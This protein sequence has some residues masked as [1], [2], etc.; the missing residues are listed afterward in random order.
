MAFTFPGGYIDQIG[1]TFFFYFG[2][3]KP[4]IT[5]KNKA[6]VCIQIKWITKLARVKAR[7]TKFDYVHGF[8]VSLGYINIYIYIYIY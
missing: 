5:F 2:I 3:I 7:V 6:N 4:R 8:Y 1:L